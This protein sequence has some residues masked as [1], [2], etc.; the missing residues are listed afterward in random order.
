MTTKKKLL[1]ALALTIGACNVVA[2][3]EIPKQE[4]AALATQQARCDA[5]RKYLQ[6]RLDES[7]G[8]SFKFPQAERYQAEFDAKEECRF[9]GIR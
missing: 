2:Q 3:F 8:A 4:A 5:A 1:L 7:A 6:R 9:R